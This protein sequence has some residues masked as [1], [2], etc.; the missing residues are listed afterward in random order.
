MKSQ[1]RH[2]RLVRTVPGDWLPVSDV[3]G[4]VPEHMIIVCAD[5]TDT[6]GLVTEDSRYAWRRGCE[7]AFSV[8]PAPITFFSEEIVSS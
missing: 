3:A 1:H 5:G 6:R 2:T 7:P 8:V 4:R